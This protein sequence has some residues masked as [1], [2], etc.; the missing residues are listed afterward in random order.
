MFDVLAL[1]QCILLL[2]AATLSVQGQLHPDKPAAYARLPSLREQAKIQ[3]QWKDERIAS[4]PNLLSKHG[5]DGWLM[6]MREHAEDPVWW[7]IKNATDFDAH[8]RTILL[9]HKRTHHP[10]LPNPVKWVDNTG[11]AW[12]SLLQTLDDLGLRRIAI[13][14]SS[15]IAFAGALPVGEL[16]EL[17]MHL[18]DRWTQRMVNVPELAIE[19]VATRVDGMLTYY[20][21]LQEIVWA[22]LEEGF[23]HRAI[24]PRVTTTRDLEW[25]FREKMQAQNVSTWNHPRISVIVPESF[26]GWEGTDDIIQEG[27]LLHIDFGITAMG[28]NTDTQHMSYVLRTTEGE[29]D[30]PEGLK[31]GMAKANRMQDIVLGHMQVGRT[32]NEVLSLALR[33]MKE[34]GIEGQ[35]YCHPIGDW[36][37]DAGAVMGFTNLPEFVPILGEL[38][39]L[40]KTYYSIELYAYHFVPERNETLRFRLEENAYWAKETEKWEFVRGRQERLHLIDQKKREGHPTEHPSFLVQ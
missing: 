26:P 22:M 32:G 38:Q 12:P 20:R 15:D 25:W 16:S 13:Q 37:H 4:V 3:D 7:S 1:I 36:G 14:T 39:I 24:E 10:A 9:F 34:E 35:I 11:D 8:R 6:S 21:D 2:L 30:A 19:Y 29:T 17:S 5:V 33:Q 31:A 23:S 18:G 27:D 28:L 40:P